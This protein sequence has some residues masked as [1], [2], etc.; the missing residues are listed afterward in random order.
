MA[1]RFFP[2]WCESGC[3][4]AHGADGNFLDLEESLFGA[5][6][7]LLEGG[8]VDAEG[9]VLFAEAFQLRLQAFIA[10]GGDFE[11]GVEVILEVL[12]LRFR[13]F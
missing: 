9:F 3:L 2:G 6:G 13:P 11:L 7:F 12:E 10:A 5:A 8:L 4:F 1:E